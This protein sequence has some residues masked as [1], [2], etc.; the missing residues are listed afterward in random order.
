[1][2]RASVYNVLRE[3]EARIVD[4][5]GKAKTK[6]KRI[7]YADVVERIEK[8]RSKLMGIAA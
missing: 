3:H 8:Q 4:F 2:S 1:M 6:G 7:V 5:S